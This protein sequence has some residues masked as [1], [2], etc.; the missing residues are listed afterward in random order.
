MSKLIKWILGIIAALVLLIVAAVVVL[1]LVIDPND[2]KDEIAKAVHEQTGRELV[3]KQPLDL[4]VFPWLGVSTGGVT[5]GNAKGFGKKPFARI[6]KLQLKVKVLPLF[7][8]KLQVDTVVVKGLVLNLA[9]KAKGRTNWD[10][11]AGKGKGKA[12]AKGPAKGPDMGA[13]SFHVQGVKVVNARVVWNDRQAMARYVLKQVNLT[14]GALSAGG[15]TPI[16]LRFVLNTGKKGP[17]VDV[18]LKGKLQVRDDLMGYR[19]PNLA[20]KVK[21][22]GGDLPRPLQLTLQSA[23]NADL[24]AEK[25]ALTKLKAKVDDSTLTGRINIG[26]FAGPA[27]QMRLTLDQIDLDRYLPGTEQKG[28]KAPAKTAAPAGDPLAPLRTLELDGR[29]DIGKLKVK[30]LHIRKIKLTVKSKDGVL[31]VDPLQAL[32]YK[33]KL[34]GRAELDARRKTPRIAVR[35][36]LVKVQAGPLLKDLTGKDR[37]TGTGEVHSNLRMRGMT[38]QAIRNSL[39]GTARFTFRDGAVKGIN[40]ANLIRQAQAKLSGGKVPDQPQQTDFSELSGSAK[41]TK[42][43]VKNQD[44]AAKSPL[45]RVAGKGRVNLPKNRVNYLLTTELVKTLEGQGGKG[46]Q[47]LTGV[48]IPVRIK[49]DLANPSYSVDLQSVFKSKVQ[50]EVKKKLESSIQDKSGDKLKGLTNG[51]GL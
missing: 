47:D 23:V 7:S 3:I 16:T 30:N 38:E 31:Q 19:M 45:L 17:V 42:G 20:L 28:K 29:I 35:N 2:Y 51:F 15:T 37:L 11:L 36:H 50:D 18:D 8:G 5:L 46:A 21:G 9:R 22:H 12:K 39:N 34:S 44:L 14:T 1:P 4:S 6:G 10:D 27:L 25:V 24:A 41:I 40:V 48:P 32:L 26:A 13:F 43:I 49:G 33:G